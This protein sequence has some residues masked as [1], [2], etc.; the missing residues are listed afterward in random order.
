MP[1]NFL[2]GEETFYDKSNHIDWQ[3]KRIETKT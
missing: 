3:T 1:V 2:H